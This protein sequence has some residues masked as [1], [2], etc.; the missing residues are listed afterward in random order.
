MFLRLY[1]HRVLIGKQKL[2][3]REFQ[4]FPLHLMLEGNSTKCKKVITVMQV[5]HLRMT[6]WLYMHELTGQRK[7]RIEIVEEEAVITVL[8]VNHL[9]HVHQM[10]GTTLTVLLE[11]EVMLHHLLVI[12][13]ETLFRTSMTIPRINQVRS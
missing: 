12:H 9:K 13:P 1:S 8:L 5:Q 4:D 2:T 6:L 3:L 10:E 7:K 11:Q